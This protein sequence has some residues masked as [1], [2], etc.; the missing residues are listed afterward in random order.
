MTPRW[1][2]VCVTVMAIAIPNVVLGQDAPSD[3]PIQVGMMLGIEHFTRDMPGN[4]EPGLVLD[5]HVQLPLAQ[6]RLAVRGDVMYHGYF[7]GSCVNTLGFG[8]GSCR[9]TPFGGLMSWSVDLVARLNDPR[10]R[11]SPYVLA[12]AGL[13]TN[14]EGGSP[15]TAVGVQGGFGFEV[16]PGKRGVVFI[17]WRHLN[18]G[19]IGL[20]PAA[21][22]MRF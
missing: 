3:R 16:R 20:T 14:A 4:N 17:E 8:G 19:S 6:R 18:V 7:V 9:S 22:G 21:I 2:A 11:W 1:R 13:Y 10:T 15:P 5:V 12:G